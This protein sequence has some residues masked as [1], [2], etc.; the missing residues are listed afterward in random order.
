MEWFKNVNIHTMTLNV[1]QK[2]KLFFPLSNQNYAKYSRGSCA[3]HYLENGG[4]VGCCD[5]LP[6]STLKRGGCKKENMVETKT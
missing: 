2:E 3:R 1:Y 5:G 4:T 6:C